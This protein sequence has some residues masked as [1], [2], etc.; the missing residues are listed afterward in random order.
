[1]KKR[2]V[3][4]GVLGTVK[5]ALL[6][7]DPIRW[8]KWRPTIAIGMNKDLNIS[9]FELLYQPKY[10]SIAQYVADDFKQVSQSSDVNLCEIDI[11]EP[12]NFERVYETLLDFA[13]SY[14]FDLDNEEY[15]VHITTGT[16]VMQICLFLLVESRIIPARILQTGL[17][18]QYSAEGICNIIDLDLSKYDSL[19]ERFKL[20]KI[21]SEHYLKS[22]IPTKNKQ[23]NELIDQLEV[24]CM[25]S[26]DPILITGPS[27]VGKTRLAR[28]I[29][30]LK[31]KNG[32]VNN[33]FVELNCATLQGGMASSAL[34][35]HQKGSYTGATEKRE[36]LLLKA[37]GGLL[38]LDEVGELGLDEQAMLLRALEEKRFYPL[39]SDVEN[40]SNFQLICGTNRDLKQMVKDGKFRGDLLARI[41]LWSFKLL[42][43]HDRPEDLEPNLEYELENV[44]Q[45][46]NK[47]IR[48]NKEAKDLFIKKLTTGTALWTG[49]FREL[50]GA[51]TRMSVLAD[52]GRIKVNDVEKEVERLENGWAEDEVS[53]I[54]GNTSFKLCKKLLG[55]KVQELDLFDLPQ[56][57]TVIRVCSTSK[58]AS[59]AGRRLFN[60]SIKQKKSTNDTDRLK[61]YLDKYGL[62]FSEITNASL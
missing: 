2:T 21:N 58:T 27:G 16:H 5:D 12:W 47:Q 43:L 49:N 52:G 25:N 59:D 4:I 48:M 50:S 36:G 61:K 42:G 1:M 18:D 31:H 20:D 40:H 54:N 60:S 7:N 45:K 6:M 29:F 57:E 24:V 8:E 30:E 37:D 39:G 62:S 35:G 14:P 19:A 56:L 17:S 11:F 55:E 44:S 28:L 13:K 15:L 38:F 26:E 34:F 3:V 41:N 23:Y 33:K 22:G 10:K 53:D 51:V 46:L 32:K 9:R